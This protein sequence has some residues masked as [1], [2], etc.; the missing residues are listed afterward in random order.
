MKKLIKHVIITDNLDVELKH[1]SCN[2]IKM[3]LIALYTN[4]DII[5]PS[6]LYHKKLQRFQQDYEKIEFLKPYITEIRLIKNTS[7]DKS[8]L[9][10]YKEQLNKFKSNLKSHTYYKIPVNVVDCL[11][12]TKITKIQL[13]FILK[14]YSVLRITYHKS[15][16]Y[17]IKDFIKSTFGD[18][19]RNE[20]CVKKVKLGDLISD[21]KDTKGDI[22]V[23][24]SD[25]KVTISDNKDTQWSSI[26]YPVRSDFS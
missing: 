14:F 6:T 19:S 24:I 12:H 9:K 22:K 17:D 20:M 11:I 15:H 13:L 8:N 1:F 26:T 2:Q 7:F 4:D 3:I 23:T 18:V 16:T 25:N 21:N 5:I 10:E